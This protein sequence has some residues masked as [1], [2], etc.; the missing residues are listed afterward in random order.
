MSPA[1][2]V[3]AIVCN[4]VLLGITGVI[5]VTEGMPNKAPYLVLTLLMLL[6]PLL[7]ALVVLRGG[8]ALPAAMPTRELMNRAVAVCNVALLGVAGWA[9]ISQYPYPEGN[10]VIPFA[11]LTVCTPMLSLMALVG[12]S[13]RAI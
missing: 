5:V 2:R 9:V 10:S 13:S 1:V 3:T 12:G 6:V 11:I 4:V 7:T 8:T